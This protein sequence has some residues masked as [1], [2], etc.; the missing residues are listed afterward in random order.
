MDLIRAAKELHLFKS[1]NMSRFP[2]IPPGLWRQP[3]PIALLNP[4]Q[5]DVV[6]VAT[7]EP[8]ESLGQ[9]AHFL[10]GHGSPRANSSASAVGAILPIGLLGK[11]KAVLL[12]NV[13]AVEI[14]E[15]IEA[16]LVFIE[17][18]EVGQI[19]NNV[20]ATPGTGKAV[21]PRVAEVD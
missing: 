12:G 19:L 5:L 15:I 3:C 21:E 9:P 11:P 1:A 6:G 18:G 7:Q 17:E 2:V 8:H 14:I 16:K 20:I 4:A 13:K 10:P